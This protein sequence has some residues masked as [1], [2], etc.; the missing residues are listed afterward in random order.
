V[1]LPMIRHILPVLLLCATLAPAAA[2]AEQDQVQ[3]FSNIHVAPGSAIHDAVCFFCS[4]DIEG[5]ATGDI[6]VFFGNVHVAS[7]AEHDVVSFFGNVT[8]DDNASID[9]DLV[10]MF[11]NIRLGDNVHIGEDL[12]AMFGTLHAAD[13]ISVEGDRVVQPAWLFYGPMIILV[14]VLVLV[15]REF[16]AWRRRNYLR[17]WGYPPRP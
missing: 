10:S 17:T 6:V 12:V 8:A 3:F 5:Q 4:V 14:V 9:H 13:N 1:E 15:I 11:G 16:R 2:R 7:S